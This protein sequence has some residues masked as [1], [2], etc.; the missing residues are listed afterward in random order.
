L[1]LEADNLLAD[2]GDIHHDGG[3]GEALGVVLHEGAG[4]SGG[5]AI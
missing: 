3:A 2:G 5:H 4:A 1:L